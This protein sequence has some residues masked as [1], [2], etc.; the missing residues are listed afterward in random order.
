MIYNQDYYDNYKRGDKATKV[1][2]GEYAAHL[3]G[4]PSNMETALA[5]ALYLTS[6]EKNADVVEMT[7]Y[8]P[9]LSKDGHTQWRPDLIYFSNTDVRPTTDYYVQRYFGTHGVDQYIP[10]EATLSTDDAKARARV[11]SSIVYNSAEGCYYVKLVNLLPKSV[12]ADIDLSGLNV[13]KSAEAVIEGMVGN[14]AD[15]EGAQ[16]SMTAPVSGR[17]ACVMPP[18]SFTV[19]KVKGL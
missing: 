12:D 11:G 5:E 17:L 15:T 19:I 18:Y 6:V 1:Y 9:L 10:A 8:A 4:R 7:S 2:L 13:D 14:P 3:P 16:F